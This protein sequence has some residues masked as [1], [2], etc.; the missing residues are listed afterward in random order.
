MSVKGLNEMVGR[1]IISD[2]FRS[3]LLN[4]RRAELLR[5]FETRLE[6]D[7]QQAVLAIQAR[8]L[9][10]FAAAIEQLIAER[11][12]R[13]PAAQPEP[14]ALPAMRW[15]SLSATGVYLNCE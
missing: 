13:R 8:D 10:D 14:A 7:E 9:A 4:G 3:G 1:A 6:P 11:E 15:S 5:Q 12:G 2:S